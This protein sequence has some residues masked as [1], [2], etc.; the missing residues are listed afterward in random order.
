MIGD[1]F[2]APTKAPDESAAN[3]Y[4]KTHMN[5]SDRANKNKHTKYIIPTLGECSSSSNYRTGS[6]LCRRSGCYSHSGHARHN[7]LGMYYAKARFYSA[8]DKRF[9]AMDPIKGSI[10]DPLSLGAAQAVLMQIILQNVGG[11][12]LAPP[13][14]ALAGDLDGKSLQTPT[15]TAWIIL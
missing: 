8:D 13:V 6:F 11:D 4:K 10:T 9:V 5:L 12:V 1:V 3:S 15:S 7:V 2:A 14:G